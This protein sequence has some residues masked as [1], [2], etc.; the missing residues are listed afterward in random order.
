MVR[1]SDLCGGKWVI[2]EH[3]CRSWAE[4]DIFG[5]VVGVNEV[6]LSFKARR[7]HG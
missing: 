4:A 6:E 7:G 3:E 1:V 2:W 5:E